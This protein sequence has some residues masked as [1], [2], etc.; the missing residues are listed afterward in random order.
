MDTS[1]WTGLNPTPKLVKTTRLFY[2]QYLYKIELKMEGLTNYIRW[3]NRYYNDR[4]RDIMAEFSKRYYDRHSVYIDTKLITFVNNFLVTTKIKKRIEWQYVSLYTNNLDD[5]KPLIDF[6]IEQKSCSVIKY[7]H[8]PPINEDLKTAIKSG[9]IYVKRIPEKFKYRIKLK[10]NY[11]FETRLN[12]VDYLKS[13]PDEIMI[14]NRLMNNLA[15]K[16]Y[17]YSHSGYFYCCNESTYLC[18][19]LMAPN[20][21][22]GI[23]ELIR[24]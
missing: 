8:L 17:V 3:S 2:N 10:P 16:Y 6:L 22:D 12:L 5:L 19:K 15:S 24:D 4:F 18:V 7:V 21:V 23:F 13:I 9:K 11:D 1:F 14:S 20:I